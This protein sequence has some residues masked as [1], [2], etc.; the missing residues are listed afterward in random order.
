MPTIPTTRVRAYLA[1]FETVAIAI[2]E[3]GRVVITD[4]PSGH[5]QAWC[6]ASF[7]QLHAK[8]WQ[9]HRPER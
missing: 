3:R 1:D 4:D 7:R 5:Y 6:L 2:T 8:S 9:L